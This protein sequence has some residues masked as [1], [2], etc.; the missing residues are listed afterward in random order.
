MANPKNDIKARLLATFRVEAEEHLQAITANLVA[1]DRGLP[2]A[3]AREAVETTFREVHT[4]KGAARSVSLMEVEALCQACESVLSR[5]TRGQLALSRLLVSRLQ[6]AVDGVTRLVTGNGAPIT[7]REVISRLERAAA[8]PEAHAAGP[9]EAPVAPAEA[10]AGVAAP[11]LPQTDTIRLATARLDALGTQAE[12][13]LAPKLAAAERV[14][15]AGALV[16]ALTRC[17]TVMNRVRV[18]QRPAPADG[19]AADALAALDTEL[20]AAETQARGMLGRLARDERVIAGAVDGLHEEM[21]RI[22]MVPAATVLDLFPRMVRDLAREQGKEV[23]WVA[24]GSELEV[25]RRVL[26][27]M[28][29]PLIH[30]VRNAVDHGIERPEERIRAGK[31]RQGRVAVAVASLEGGRLEL[32]VEDD[33][34]GIDLAQVRAAAARARLLSPEDA[35]ALTDEA[36]LGL[37]YRSGFSTSPIITDVSGHGL[38]LAIVKEQA[39]RLGGQIHLETRA[40]VGTTVRL[41]LP[42]TIATFR[43]LL[44]QAGQQAFLLPTE[45]VERAIRIAPGEVERVEGRAA[46][47]W[48]G[49][50]LPVARL[51]ELLGLPDRDDRPEAESRHPCVIVSSGEERAGLLV[52]EIFGDREV[53]VKELRPP[54][55]RVRNVAGAGLLGTGQVVLILRPADLLKSVRENPRQPAAPAA[56]EDEHRQPVILVV[57]DSITTRTMEKNL[58]EAAGYQVRVAVDGIEAW[59][60]LKSEEIDLVASDVDMPRMDGFDLTARIRAD[61]KLADLPVVLV[62][63]LESREDKERGIEVGANAYL[64]KSSFDQSN[65]LEII[66][67][68]V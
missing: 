16:R 1:L 60:A 40:G 53:L 4:L 10:P 44:V 27:A 56:S 23:E 66:R 17:R 43:G 29:E 51:R 7:T 65:L 14:R 24:R 39:E 67:R 57:D 35:Q 9:A 31:P 33:G 64:V 8:E 37:I 49:Q 11:R 15:E 21:R 58:L 48:N 52:D 63:A 59:T 42:A 46:I 50:P 12:G 25:D 5:I 22:R 2:A 3:E 68:L 32:R 6:E 13:L 47:R 61:R 30:L 18:A 26:E 54:L 45:A 36:V 28:K 55:V 62:T 34:R 19:P 38:G 20:R 41:I